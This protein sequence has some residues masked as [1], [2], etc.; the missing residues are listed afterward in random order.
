MALV[1]VIKSQF[2]ND[3]EQYRNSFF[4][5]FLVENQFVLVVRLILDRLGVDI[6]GQSQVVLVNKSFVFA[7]IVHVFG[8]SCIQAHFY[9][10]LVLQSKFSILLEFHQRVLIGEV[11]IF[12]VQQSVYN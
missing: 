12:L 1:S 8:K 9:G 2:L 11:F 3:F 10:V 6:D 5:H 4:I 7:E